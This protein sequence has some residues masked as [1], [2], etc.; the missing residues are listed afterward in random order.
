MTPEKRRELFTSAAE[1]CA[2]K[3]GAT[4][5]DLGKV[6]AHEPASSYAQKC[7]RACLGEKFGLVSKT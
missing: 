5:S 7:I 6:L 4:E 3:E 1:D 2:K